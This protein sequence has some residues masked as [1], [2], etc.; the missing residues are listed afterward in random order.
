MTLDGRV[1][2]VG[3]LLA[4]GATSRAEVY[5]PA[6]RSWQAGADLPVALHH[7]MAV[8]YRGEVV[9]LGGFRAE[10]PGIYGSPSDRVYALRGGRW[11]EL[12]HLHRPRGAG[13]ACAVGDEIVVVGGADGNALV[14]PTEVFDGTSW[15]DAAPVPT[16]RDHLGAATDGRWC[17]AVGGRFLSLDHNTDA[18]EAYDPRAD[19]WETLAP[20]P[21]RRGGL[22]VAF[23]AGLVIGA[24]GEA[25]SGTNGEVEAYD[26]A[27]ATWSA[28]PS[29]RTPRHGV[30]VAA[31]DS[32]VFTLTGG[33]QPGVAP[34]AS[35]ESLDLP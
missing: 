8:A 27:T 4:E 6:T 12:P 33:L 28:L 22:G 31:V 25:P 16:P 15:R 17:F 19:A 18:M 34:S 32:S 2:V 7:A 10:G 3:G 20:M 1:W 5:D 24:G 11:V 13:A 23:S 26:P 29:M 35:A 21:T 30:G 14:A 9:I